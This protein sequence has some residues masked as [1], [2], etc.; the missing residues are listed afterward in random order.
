MLEPLPEG[1]EAPL[2]LEPRPVEAPV[3]DA[4]TRART[5]WNTAK[6]SSVEA[7]TASAWPWMRPERAAWSAST[8]TT[9]RATTVV[10]ARPQPSV[11]LTSRSIS[12]RR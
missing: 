4:W 10:V 6:A 1:L 7:A 8:A 9:N 2:R 12:Y 5:G 11:R 3:D